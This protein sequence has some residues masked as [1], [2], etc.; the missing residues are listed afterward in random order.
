ME[1]VSN[2]RFCNDQPIGWELF[3]AD[4]IPSSRGGGRITPAHPAGGVFQRLHTAPRRDYKISFVLGYEASIRKGSLEVFWN[5]AS[6]L[7]G[8]D[9]PGFART[10]FSGRVTAIS[11]TSELRFLFVDT[12][13]WFTLDGVS[14]RP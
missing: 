8:V 9:F 7:K 5:G 1:L 3:N 10:P 6:I 11:N 12:G 2:G 13:G 14:V 4:V